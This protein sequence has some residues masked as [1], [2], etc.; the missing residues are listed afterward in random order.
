MVGESARSESESYESVEKPEAVEQAE[1]KDARLPQFTGELPMS[2]PSVA[3]GAAAKTVSISSRALSSERSAATL[4]NASIC[5][6]RACIT[7]TPSSR[8]CCMKEGV[9]RR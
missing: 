6:A 1:A 9:P 3:S 5:R 2:W 8:I 4:R 7:F